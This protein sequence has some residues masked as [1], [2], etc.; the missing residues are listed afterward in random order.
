MQNGAVSFSLKIRCVFQFPFRMDRARPNLRNNSGKQQI[1]SI[2]PSGATEANL[3]P[4]RTHPP[5]SDAGSSPGRKP[6][7]KAVAVWY[8]ESFRKKGEETDP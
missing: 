1:H 7:A 8:P 2:F 5:D 4:G 3:P 6:L